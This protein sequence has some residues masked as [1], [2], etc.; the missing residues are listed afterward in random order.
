MSLHS[1]KFPPIFLIRLGAD[2]YKAPPQVHKFMD[3][4]FNISIGEQTKSK[5]VDIAMDK[6]HEFIQDKIFY[7]SKEFDHY[8]MSGEII[9]EK[10]HFFVKIEVACDIK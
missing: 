3:V 7:K 4:V 10:H 8:S 6:V 5:I 1:H 9:A 2:C